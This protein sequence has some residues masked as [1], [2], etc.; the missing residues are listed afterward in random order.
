MA[1]TL[2]PDFF[3]AFDAASRVTFR[4]ENM[5]R[6]PAPVFTTDVLRRAVE[7]LRMNN[8][9]GPYVASVLQGDRIVTISMVDRS[10]AAPWSMFDKKPDDRERNRDQRAA[11]AARICAGIDAA[12]RATP[13]TAAEIRE[14]NGWRVSWRVVPR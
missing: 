7:T 5:A 2:L 14:R 4:P 13:I 8:V 12:R 11:W 1:Q 9:R 6:D 10:G 3:R